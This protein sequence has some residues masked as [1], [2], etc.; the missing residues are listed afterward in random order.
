MSEELIVKPTDAI[1]SGSLIK[2]IQESVPKLQKGAANTIE[3]TS[4]FVTVTE[5]NVEEVKALIIPVRTTREKM[6]ALRKTTTEKMDALKAYMMIPEKQV[7]DEEERLRAGVGKIE[8]EKIRKN[9]EAE[10]VAAANRIKE[11]TKADVTAKIK[12]N[13]TDVIIARCSNVEVES[14]KY[15]NDGITNMEDFEKKSETYKTVKWRMKQEEYDKC[16]IVSYNQSGITNAEYKELADKLKEDMTYEKV[17]AMF[18]EKVGPIL[19]NWKAKI[20][21]LKE[22]WTAKFAAS[23]SERARLDAESEKK[24]KEDAKRQQEYLDEQKTVMQAPVQTEQ[25]M[26]KVEADFTEQAVVQSLEKTGPKKKVLKFVNDK[27]VAELAEIIY[28]CFMHP[29]FKGIIKLND[30]KV[31]LDENGNKEYVDAVNY[32]VD[33]FASNCDAEIKN[34]VVHEYAKVIIRK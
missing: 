32:F 31:V 27:P 18:I 28:H 26:A 6:E 21:Q 24:N 16:F 4:K 10:K 1:E 2:L 30:G 13:V 29:K 12:L 3:A 8:Q 20:P 9:A 7:K 14:G 5:E 34:T 22:E 15:L 11:Q 23:E 33:F 25:V 17:N 19:N